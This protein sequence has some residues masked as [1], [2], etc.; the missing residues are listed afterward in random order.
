VGCA[1]CSR[2]RDEV[3]ELDSWLRRAAA[4]DVRAFDDEG[5]TE[6]PMGDPFRVRP[7]PRLKGRTGRL[8]GRDVVEAA[9]DAAEAAAPLREELLAWSGDAARLAPLFGRIEPSNLSNRFALLQALQGW[10]LTLAESP[11]RAL[12]FAD[13]ALTLLR[14]DWPRPQSEAEHVVPAAALR[15]QAHLLAGQ[16]CN[17]TKEF[18]RAKAHLEL[19]YR[20]FG[21]GGAD[22]ISLAMVELSESQRRSFVGRGAEAKR[23]ACRAGQS[24]AAFGLEDYLA[25]TRM[26]EGLALHDLGRHEDAI[27]AYREAL[28]VFERLE[29]WSNYVGA[30]NSIGTSLA[31]MGRLRDARREY[32]RALRRLS[33]DRQGPHLG[34]VRH[35]LADALFAGKRYREA[36]IAFSQTSRVYAAIGLVASVLIASLCEIESWARHGDLARARHRLEIFRAQVLRVGGLDPSVSAE[37]A[38]ALSGDDPDFE[39]LALLREQSQEALRR[40]LA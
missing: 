38:R 17:W 35:G 21:R 24:F 20:N 25:R 33:R 27:T 18:E 7:E 28:A 1:A 4:E 40:R 19:A 22:E 14:A 23:L 6:L 37:I 12:L 10:G 5:A 2:I 26:A 3:A 15:G 16:A 39:R 30:L 8:L 34:L 29:L 32:A 11:V 36:A 9:L 31:K 13:G